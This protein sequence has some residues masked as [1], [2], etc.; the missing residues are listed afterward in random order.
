MYIWYVDVYLYL[1]QLFMARLS[2][3]NIV[4]HFCHENKGQFSQ[5][6]WDIWK[7]KL[8]TFQGLKRHQIK[9]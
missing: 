3:Q 9:G 7:K 8:Q 2:S 5:E 1:L 6:T 4:D